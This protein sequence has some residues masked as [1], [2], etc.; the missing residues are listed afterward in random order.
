MRIALN[1]RCMSR[2]GEFELALQFTCPQVV[3]SLYEQS[4]THF[5]KHK[6]LF[7]KFQ[8]KSPDV[9][10]TIMKIPNFIDFLCIKDNFQSDCV[11]FDM[12]NVQNIEAFIN[13]VIDP[14]YIMLY[15]CIMVEISGV[16]MRLK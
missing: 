15:N 10:S 16:K 12:N 1:D 2:I 8:L 14:L 3:S 7:F 5:N 9:V 4:I 6:H 13:I 11:D